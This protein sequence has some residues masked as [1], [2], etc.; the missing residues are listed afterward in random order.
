MNDKLPPTDFPDLTNDEVKAAFK[1]RFKEQRLRSQLTMERLANR[2]G[3]TK[4]GISGL[5]NGR[6]K[7]IKHT[8]LKLLANALHCTEDYLLLK[9][10]VPERTGSGSIQ[11]I[12]IATEDRFLPLRIC[13]GLTD[14]A[15]KAPD[16]VEILIECNNLSDHKID[17][18]SKLIKVFL[19]EF[20][21]E[22]KAK[23][24]T[25]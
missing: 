6:F 4:A 12:F 23:P 10:D 17:V 20:S 11:P 25:L 16:F 8:T 3:I 19:D 14:L 2:V 7:T 13:D 21:S 18:L 1:K 24:K 5:E 9:S 15:K 22:N